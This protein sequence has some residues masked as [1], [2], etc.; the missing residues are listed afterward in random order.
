MLIEFK[1]GNFLSFKK[2]VTL[3]MVAMRRTDED[4]Q[5]NLFGYH[6]LNILKSTAIY[7]ANA[8]G[9]SNFIKALRFYRNYIRNSSIGTQVDE[10]IPIKRFV[11]SDDI[12]DEPAFFEATFVH[13]SVKYRYGF[14]ATENEI[15]GEWLFGA[16]KGRE[17][18]FFVRNRANIKIGD[19]FKQA[20][21]LDKVTRDNALFLSVAAQF[22]NEQA[23][24]IFEWMNDFN[25]I[26]GLDDHHYLPYTLERIE[27]KKNKNSILNLLKVADLSISD[28][29]L[30]TQELSI[31]DLEDDQI[32]LINDRINLVKKKLTKKNDSIELDEKIIQNELKTVHRKYNNEKSSGQYEFSLSEESKGT[33]KL[34]ALAGPIIDTLENGKVLVVDELEAR[35]HPLLTKYIVSLFNSKKH[36]LNNAQLIFVTHDVNFLRNKTLRRDQVWFIEKNR[37]GA[38][39]L[40]SMIE[41][42]VRKDANYYSDYLSGKYGAIPVIHTDE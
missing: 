40:F 37:Y 32:A 34:L 38:S 36:N 21:G 13:N 26:S 11:L 28:I 23:K 6:D 29:R 27:D 1:V 30:D 16:P 7:G 3:S 18:E 10:R 20:K 19:Y 41:Y 25:V 22:N 14:E 42:N 31:N 15:I 2:T 4:D 8:S 17:A 39:D 5:P 9:K 12:A 24:N 35:L 33:Q